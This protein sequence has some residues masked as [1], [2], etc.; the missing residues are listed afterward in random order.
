MKR[1]IILLL[2]FVLGIHQIIIAQVSSGGIPA[3]FSNK[4]LSENIPQITIPSPDLTLLAN[5]DYK[6][7]SLNLPR[8]FMEIVPIDINL[9]EA[10]IWSQLEDGSRVG[11]LKVKSHNA[12]AFSLYFDRFF[13]PKGAKLFLYDENNMQM[14]GAFTEVNN[15]DDQS[16]ATELIY[17]DVV[18]LEINC[19]TISGENPILHI[20]G[21]GYAYRDIPEFTTE[22]GFGSSDFCEVNINCAP[23]GNGWQTVKSGVIRIQVKVGGSAYWCTGSLVNN[24]RNDQKPYVLTA[25]HCAYQ[26]GH[27]ASSTDLLQ[28]LF[29]F[30]YESAVCD[31]P[32]QEPQLY[33]MVGASKVAHGGERGNTGSDFYLALLSQN[34]PSA[35]HPYFIGWSA[36]NEPSLTGRSIHHPQGDIKKISTYTQPLVSTNWINN[37]LQSHWKVFWSETENGWG[38]TEGGS[39]GSPLLNNNGR[40]VGTLTGGYAAC[41]SAGVVG[42]DKPDYYGKFSYHWESNGTADT[43]QLRP[44]LDPDNTGFVNLDGLYMGIETSQEIMTND[45]IIFPNPAQ[46]LL[47]INFVNFE[48]SNARVALMDI[49]GRVI[50]L[51][52]LD[53]QT[54]EIKVNI[55]ELVIGV[56]VLG[57]ESEQ[58]NVWKRFI[59]N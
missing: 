18:V 17:G 36:V 34:V 32:S 31:N 13:L 5:E 20:S 30:N 50:K 53:K 33:S 3:T 44:W 58:M 27:Y 11:L 12:L 4:Y 38:V 2:V 21:F 49:T 40:I 57:I 35:Y 59:K 14:K 39:S 10:A 41:E 43:N 9:T 54:T 19:H 56:Y 7:D 48:P 22:K 46:S 23:E 6:N 45:I 1:N 52:I 15:T 16:F 25:D 24:V 47:N 42:P 37:T 28:W 8:R 55:S 51:L 26:L 29:Y